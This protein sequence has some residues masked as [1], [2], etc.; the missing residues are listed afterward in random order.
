MASNQT[1][2]FEE[3]MS[4]VCW[5]NDLVGFAV[6]WTTIPHRTLLNYFYDFKTDK[7]KM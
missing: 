7:V 1:T 6:A 5:F 2:N 4:K 3:S